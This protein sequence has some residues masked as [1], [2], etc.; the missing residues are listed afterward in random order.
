VLY[1]SDPSAPP[2]LLPEIITPSI[3]TQALDDLH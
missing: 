2:K 1:S 3:V